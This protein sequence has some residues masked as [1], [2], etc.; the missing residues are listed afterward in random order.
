MLKKNNDE[1]DWLRVVRIDISQRENKSWRASD[2]DSGDSGGAAA[3][4]WGGGRREEAWCARTVAFQRYRHAKLIFKLAIRKVFWPHREDCAMRRRNWE[5]R[6]D[7]RI[8]NL[9]RGLKRVAFIIFIPIVARYFSW[10]GKT[11]YIQWK[12]QWYDESN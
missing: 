8:A 12:I 6:K 1:L 11:Q 9:A 7:E 4:G 2:G 5:E 3:I 10:H